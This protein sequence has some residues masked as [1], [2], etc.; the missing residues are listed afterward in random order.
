MKRFFTILILMLSVFSIASAHPFKNN[1]ELQDFYTKID[2]EVDKELKKDYI[3]LFEERK[4]N[5][6]EKA[7][8]D[9]TEKNLEDDEYLFVFKN[10]KLEMV[11]KKE[12]LNGKFIILSYMYENGKKE[13]IVCLN[14]EN[15]HYYGTVKG[16]GEDGIPLYSG[17]FYA[18]KMEGMYKEYYDSGKL[19]MEAHF[20]NN[21]ENGLE[22]IY[23][24]NGKISSIKN[25]KDGKADG[26]Y[27]EYYT[28]GELK[29]KGSYKNGLRE[30]EFKTYLMNSKSAGSIFYKDGKEVKSTLTDYMKEDVFFNFPDKIE[31][32]M[33]VG[34]E[35][36]KELI[37]E[38][39]EHGGYHMLGIDT[40][41]NG[42][43]MRVV[44][45]NQQG[46]YD[47]TFK[48]YYESGQLAQKGYYKNGLGQGEYI[49]YYEEGSI[50][51]KA[52]YK[53]DKI[54]G[55]VTSF[56]PGGKIAQ[57]V[58]YINGKREGEL[59]E[60]YENGQIKEKRFYINDK[61]EGKSLFYDEKG[62]LVKTEIYKN[63]IKQ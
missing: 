15:S 23:Y 51:Q 8:D 46:I 27:I 53:D 28:D 55:I 4:A 13:K 34:D 48:Q 1:K 58:N 30:G 5:L 25:Y 16:F 45:Y 62:K 47:G 3:K 43:V 63:G 39:E 18:G 17:Q 50:K 7:S 41:P 40:Y 38:M 59:I 12:I 35:K 60:Y 54:E 14:K 26:E 2:K 52:F 33:N 21:K 32:Q 61:E 31:A 10:E 56:Y 37:K 44:P 24:E 11:F 57:T 36:E 19:L 6:K 49:W 42:R 22:K 20:S 29:L 9:I